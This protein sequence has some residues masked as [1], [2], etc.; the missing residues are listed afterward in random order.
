MAVS[1]S[2]AGE[3]QIE[4]ANGK[5]TTVRKERGQ[6]GISQPQVAFD[7]SIGW[8]AD[9]RVVGAAEPISGTLVVWRLGKI[10]R[11]FGSEQC[12]YSWAFFAHGTRVAYH[13]GPLHGDQRSHCELRDVAS[14]RL[15]AVWDGDLEGTTDRPDW[16]EG[17]SH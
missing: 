17:L 2:P 6:V 8:L 7:G 12:F 10:V 15:L 13:T 14:G 16:T 4:F 5:K 3:A 9:Y 1:T 11:R